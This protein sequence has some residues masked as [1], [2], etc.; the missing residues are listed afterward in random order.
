ME[1][2]SK[3][4]KNLEKSST[5]PFKRCSRTHI[6]RPLGFTWIKTIFHSHNQNTI[7]I[8][9][10]L[11]MIHMVDIALSYT[12]RHVLQN[13]TNK[14]FTSDSFSC[15]PMKVCE[16]DAKHIVHFC[17]MHCTCFFFEQL[18]QLELLF[19]WDAAMNVP[20]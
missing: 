6:W 8:W 12:L 18:E 9:Y 2:E 17:D 20:K 14:S 1:A 19:S 4:R 7:R 10:F 16:P 11:W 3:S 15:L 13:Y 5:W